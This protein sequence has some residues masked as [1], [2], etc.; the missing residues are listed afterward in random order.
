MQILDSRLS[1]AYTAV[2][3]VSRKGWTVESALQISEEMILQ[4]FHPDEITYTVAISACEKGWMAQ[5]TLQRFEAM[6]LQGL[7]QT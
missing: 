4:G 6:Q 3:S 2:M 5:R 7:Q 1:I